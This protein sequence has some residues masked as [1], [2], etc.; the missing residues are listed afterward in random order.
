[1]QSNHA[2]TMSRVAVADAAV[3]RYRDRRSAQYAVLASPASRM[4]SNPA[5]AMS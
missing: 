4:T 5:Q 2:S 3:V 1:M